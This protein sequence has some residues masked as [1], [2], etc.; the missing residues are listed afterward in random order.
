MRTENTPQPSA[1][2]SNVRGLSQ[3]LALA[4]IVPRNYESV[5]SWMSDL[6][7]TLV[8]RKRADLSG[9][10]A[11]DQ[12]ELISSRSRIV[13]TPEELRSKLQISKAV[14]T[15]L[16]VKFGIDPTGAEV[17]LGHAVPLMVADRFQR[18]GHKVVLVIGDVTAKIGDPSGRV[19]GRPTL[20][21]EQIAANYT[22]YSSQVHPI[23]DTSQIETRRN[24]DW[25][26]NL[27]A[28][29]FVQHLAQISMA[30][31]LQ[32][33]DF[34]KR[35]QEGTGLTAAETMYP[36]LMAEDSLQIRPDIE[37]GGIDQLLNLGVCRDLMAK[38]GMA[39]ETIVVTDLLIGTS[40]KGQKMSKSLGNGV[41][42]TESPPTK[43]RKLMELPNIELVEMYLKS[44][45]EIYDTEIAH[46]K[47]ALTA[48]QIDDARLRKL[49]ANVVID[50]IHGQGESAIAHRQLEGGPQYPDISL[51]QFQGTIVELLVGIG[52]AQSNSEA[53]RLIQQGGVKIEGVRV[54]DHNIRIDPNWANSRLT[55]G[56]SKFYTLK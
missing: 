45:T 55:V 49:L 50:T 41:A 4:P 16:V 36:V 15:P 43:L 38:Q 18:M 23:I 2:I 20:S 31:L 19:S 8:D 21:N 24:S 51:D 22:S 9:L 44:L 28:P 39:P 40:G 1:E 5:E 26:N 42:L 52:G 11:E 14:N 47:D 32:R 53:R 29:Q 30:G 7:R 3:A 56:K 37:I 35:L 12:F 27:S 25:L 6:E 54:T 17:H 13:T 48:G 46:L 34:K 33:E 10:S